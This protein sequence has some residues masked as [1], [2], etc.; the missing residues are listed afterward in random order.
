[1]QEQKER[2]HDARVWNKDSFRTE[3][4]FTT[5]RDIFE[6]RILSNY[7]PMKSA[8][9]SRMSLNH[10][11]RFSPYKSSLLPPRL[12][13][14]TARHGAHLRL[15]R[16][17]RTAALDKWLAQNLTPESTFPYESEIGSNQAICYVYMSLL[18]S[19]NDGTVFE[20]PD[21]YC[22][23]LEVEVAGSIHGSP[24]TRL[25]RFV[26]SHEDADAPLWT[27]ILEP[28]KD[29]IFVQPKNFIA[30][31][32]SGQTNIHVECIFTHTISSHMLVWA[33]SITDRMR[34]LLGDMPNILALKCCWKGKTH[35]GQG[36]PNRSTNEHSHGQEMDTS[37]F[38]K[39]EL[40]ALAIGRHLGYLRHDTHLERNQTCEGNRFTDVKERIVHTSDRE[41]ADT[42]I[43]ALSD[44][45]A[46]E[47]ARY[48][49]GNVQFQ[50]LSPKKGLD[51][52]IALG[53]P[54]GAATVIFTVQGKETKFGNTIPQATCPKPKCDIKTTN[55]KN[56]CFKVRENWCLMAEEGR[57][58]GFTFLGFRCSTATARGAKAKVLVSPGRIRSSI[59]SGETPICERNRSRTRKPATNRP[60]AGPGPSRCADMSA[61][62]SVLAALDT[63][64][65][66]LL[67]G[68]K[69]NIH[70]D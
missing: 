27:R 15:A 44:Y 1:M 11:R 33:S 35:Q 29:Y 38:K 7:Y 62:S 18:K 51:E 14:M 70:T 65:K 49:K 8:N 6:A 53:R 55:I 13:V 31:L 69:M 3:T 10:S 66:G 57:Q 42:Q 4:S 59:C 63:D 36:Q 32:I 23:S 47:G 37:S 39:K 45:A 68:S 50:E 52:S 9:P 22:L 54:K 64:E 60:A 25:D 12:S 58:L 17:A 67:T 20:G 19:S 56:K 41:L 21:T 46:P 43:G 48:E 61:K 16:L 40:D 28:G 2:S 24:L 34:L 30:A 5:S 26:G